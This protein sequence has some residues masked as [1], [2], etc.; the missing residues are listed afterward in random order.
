MTAHS[1]LPL[2]P[3]QPVLPPH[4]TLS[5]T[6]LLGELHCLQSQL[7]GGRENEGTGASLSAA[8]LESL[9]HGDEEAG[10]LATACPGHGHHVF[11]IQDHRDGLERKREGG[12]GSAPARTHHVT[13]SLLAN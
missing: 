9:E 5:L 12:A 2:V 7:P 4:P 8:G 6:H 3:A 1:G 11:A 13:Q 10:S